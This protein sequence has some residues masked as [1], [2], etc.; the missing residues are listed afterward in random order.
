[1]KTTTFPERFALGREMGIIDSIVQAQ[2]GEEGNGIG[3]G[4][5][6]VTR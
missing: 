5:I 2:S 1:M 3:R 6:M 4:S